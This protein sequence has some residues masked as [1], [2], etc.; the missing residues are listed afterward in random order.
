PRAARLAH[1]GHAASGARRFPHGGGAVYLP[2]R[3][4]AEERRTFAWPRHRRDPRCVRLR[5]RRNRGVAARRC[6]LNRSRTVNAMLTIPRRRF[7]VGGALGPLALRM[8]GRAAAPVDTA[9][10]DQTVHL[11]SDGLDLSPAG[12][13]RLLA[14]LV[15]DPGIEADDY[16]RGG[17]VGELER[18]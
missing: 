8:E 10:Q 11:C 4:A 6:D 1:L 5:A 15:A 9:V 13:A 16:S 14:R 17:V 18:R 7:L 2:G 12:Y 3:D